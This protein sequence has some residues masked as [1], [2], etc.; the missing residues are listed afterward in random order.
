MIA[1]A[2][3]IIQS[4]QYYNYV[5]DAI[6]VLFTVGYLI[7]GFKRG[8]ARSLWVLFFDVITIVSLIVIWKFLFPLFVGMIPVVGVGL[9][10]KASTAFLYTSFYRFFIKMIM[11]LI[12]FYILRCRIFKS[13]LRKM[14]E[15]Y[16]DHTNKKRFVGRVFAAVFSA[17]IAF[18]LSS[19]SIS[20]ANEYTRSSNRDESSKSFIFSNYEE[21]VNETY[22]AKYSLKFFDKLVEKMVET[23]SIINPHQ[24]MVQLITEE[25]Y[26]FDE[27]PSYRGAI[28]R[29]ITASTPEAYLNLVE[30]NTNDGL[31]TFSMDLQTWAMYASLDNYDASFTTLDNFVTPILEEAIERGY[32]YT[33]DTSK[34]ANFDDYKAEFSNE[35][36]NKIR[37]IFG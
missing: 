35:A 29:M 27:V 3:S 31:V 25:Q 21:E 18:I 23:D 10:K 26:T 9:F 28:Y 6:V 8:F 15:Y 36:Y 2:L 17:G 24:A 19:G 30:A 22:V 34:L 7:A 13:I 4:F 32:T 16:I 20:L 33:G 11:I 12:I 14:H 1:K 5:F 37:T